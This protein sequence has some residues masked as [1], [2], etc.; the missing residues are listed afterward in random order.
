MRPVLSYI[1]VTRNKL[2]FLKHVLNRLIFNCQSDEEII[3]IDGASNDGTTEFLNEVY[4]QGLIHKFIS[5]PDISEGHA[6]NK[7]MLLAEG[8]LIKVMTD[9]DV[10]D[11]DIIKKCK[12]FMIQNLDIHYMNSFTIAYDIK[13]EK[14]IPHSIDSEAFFNW[15]NL[16]KRPYHLCG[17]GLMIRKSSLP[18]LGLFKVDTKLPDLEYSL[19]ITSLPVNAAWCSGIVAIQ[20]LNSRSISR[21]LRT[22]KWQF[23][24]KRYIDYYQWEV[25]KAEWNFANNTVSYRIKNIINK[26]KRLIDLLKNG[27]IEKILKSVCKSKSEQSEKFENELITI[28]VFQN[29]TKKIEELNISTGGKIYYK[30]K[31]QK[32]EVEY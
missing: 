13:N 27:E 31:N 8:E 10:F 22:S 25:S 24:M 2:Q 18:L 6:F 5:E 29:M 21:T 20:L 19:R 11:F 15:L 14:M 4:S 16:N 3:V 26:I 9:D 17:L 32:F 12:S 23:E 7:G 1:I 28:D 30:I